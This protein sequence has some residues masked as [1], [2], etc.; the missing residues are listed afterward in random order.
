M[1][2][3]EFKVRAKWSSKDALDVSVN[4]KTHQVFIDDKLPLTIS[5]DK[6]FKGDTTKYNPEDLLLSA[7]SS[8]HMM[9]YFYV[10]AQNGIELIDYKSEAIGVLELKPDGSG[11]FASVVLHLDILVSNAEMIADAT[12]LHKQANTLCFIAN[13]VNFPIEHMV[14]VKN[15]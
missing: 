10:C 6:A 4:G 15:I 1:F 12:H 7:L 3:K 8:C 13:S 11:A 5:A 14:V 2:K 9:S